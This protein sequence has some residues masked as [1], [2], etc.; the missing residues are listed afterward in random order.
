MNLTSNSLSF[1]LSARRLK[2][3]SFKLARAACRLAQVASPGLF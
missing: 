1:Q 3:G 2:I